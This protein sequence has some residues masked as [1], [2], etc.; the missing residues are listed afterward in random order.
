MQVALFFLCRPTCPFAPLYVR[1][2]NALYTLCSPICVLLGIPTFLDDPSHT[3]FTPLNLLCALLHPSL[4]PSTSLFIPLYAP[5]HLLYP[6]CD[7]VYH[8][9]PFYTPPCIP[10]YDP[11]HLFM[12]LHTQS[13]LSDWPRLPTTANQIIHMYQTNLYKI[14]TFPPPLSQ[15]RSRKF[16]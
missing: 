7:F 13:E 9:T 11:L 1:F 14:L 4:W 8:S 2:C 6:L 12:P 5:P 15:E 16:K 10:I 3:L